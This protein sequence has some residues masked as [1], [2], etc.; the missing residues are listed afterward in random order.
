MLINFYKKQNVYIYVSI[1]Y[2]Y[3]LILGN[4]VKKKTKQ[5]NKKNEHSPTLKTIKMVE[6]T[7]K[8]MDDSIM[9]ISELKK[10]LPKKI[11]HITLKKIID[12]LEE[13]NK[14]VTSHKGITWIV[15]NSPKLKR[16]IAKGMN[17]SEFLKMLRN[18]GIK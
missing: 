8:N 16:A 2:I 3:V 4:M 1:S 10:K 6:D 14:I 13:S 7:L 18:A 9:K 11:N 12:Y 15:N 17:Y 5:G